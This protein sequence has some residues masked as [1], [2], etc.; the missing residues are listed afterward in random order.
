MALGSAEENHADRDAGQNADESAPTSPAEVT[1][2]RN[3]GRDKPAANRLR[4]PT[5]V[6]HQSEMMSPGVVAGA[7]G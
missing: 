6:A 3:A 2:G 7:G 4:N 5:H 1:H